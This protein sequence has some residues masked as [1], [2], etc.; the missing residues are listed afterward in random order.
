MSD[1]IDDA[2]TLLSEA[3]GMIGNYLE[4]I[5]GAQD[6]IDRIDAYLK[7]DDATPSDTLT[8]EQFMPRIDGKSFRCECGCNV[9]KKLVQ[10]PNIFVC[11]GCANRYEGI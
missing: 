10:R 4:G 8:E 11:N 9:F 6:L 5:D 3:R 1:H 7:D 2:E